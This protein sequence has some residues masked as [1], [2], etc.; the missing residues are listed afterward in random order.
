MLIVEEEGSGD[1]TDRGL[2]CGTGLGERVDPGCIELEAGSIG[3]VLGFEVWSD[4]SS[5]YTT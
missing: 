1:T 2:E 5:S 4:S 3:S